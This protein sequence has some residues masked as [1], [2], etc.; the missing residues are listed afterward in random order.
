MAPAAS[1]IA[2]LPHREPR[3]TSRPRASSGSRSASRTRADS[4]SASSFAG[5]SAGQP[6][7]TP[8]TTLQVP[9]N[10]LIFRTDG[11]QVA[12]VGPDSRV[13][14]EKV[15]VGRDF[16]TAVEIVS[17]V[18]ADDRIVVNPPDSIAAGAV[19]RIAKDDVAAEAGSQ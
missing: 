17:G 2:L 18:T 4:P 7:P 9:V 8:A 15:S 16:G 19:V 5:L 13:T 6:L 1:F 11:L 12:K 14:L 3:F 10:V